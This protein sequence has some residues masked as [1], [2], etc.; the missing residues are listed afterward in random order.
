MHSTFFH[1]RESTR[2]R[3]GQG[4]EGKNEVGDVKYSSCWMRL[5]LEFVPTNTEKPST[6]AQGAT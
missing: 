4:D 1:F 5:R 2:R 6:H 3:Y